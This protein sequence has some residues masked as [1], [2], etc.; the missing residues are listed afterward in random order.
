M[1][2]RANALHKARKLA[3]ATQTTS[4]VIFDP[5]HLDNPP[6][7]AYYAATAEDAETFFA[8]CEIV[9]TVEPEDSLA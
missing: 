6:E 2:T 9:D 1:T 8:G 4:Y 7:L 3:K 5:A